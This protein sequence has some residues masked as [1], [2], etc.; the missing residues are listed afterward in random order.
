MLPVLPGQMTPLRQ[1]SSTRAPNAIPLGP[2]PVQLG[3]RCRCPAA[4]R[5]GR[6]ANGARCGCG[7]RRRCPPARQTPH[8]ANQ[9]LHQPGH[10][11][12][13]RSGPGWRAA[14]SFLRRCSRVA[15]VTRQPAQRPYSTQAASADLQ[16]RLCVQHHRQQAVISTPA[17]RAGQR[18]VQQRCGLRAAPPAA[19]AGRASWALV[20]KS[21][22]ITV[23]LALERG[24]PVIELHRQRCRQRNRLLMPGV[25][26]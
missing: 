5:P 1:A 19:P 17:A 13:R 4:A 14:T 11:Y 2:S 15:A 21:S 6:I 7:H 9:R 16:R 8:A 10:Q 26:T 20:G 18:G 12:G 22:V 3:R 25:A 23:R 24:Q